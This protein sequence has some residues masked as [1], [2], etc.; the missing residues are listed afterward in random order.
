[1]SNPEHDLQKACVSWFRL[2]YP[3]HKISLFAIPNAAKRSARGGKW[4]KDEGL[5]SGVSDL[6]LAVPTIEYHGLFIEMKIKPNKPTHE[7]LQF[8]EA[9]NNRK[10]KAVVC[11][12]F[13]EF[14]ETIEC[15][16]K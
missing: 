14:V 13:D 5:L 4:M 12:S 2:K 1:M 6:F 8:I 7:Q 16:L 11:Y 15:Y 9:M 3:K 10:Y